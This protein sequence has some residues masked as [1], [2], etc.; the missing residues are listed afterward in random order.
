MAGVVAWTPAIVRAS[1]LRGNRCTE[2]PA[3]WREIGSVQYHPE[4][5]KDQAATLFAN[6]ASAM[7]SAICAQRLL[8]EPLFQGWRRTSSM[9]RRHAG[10][11]SN[12]SLPG[13][14]S[15]TSPGIG[16]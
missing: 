12:Q 10:R 16:T 15:D 8:E 3:D 4:T 9:W 5:V 13:V 6:T 2:R 14:A 7:M 11:A 1:W